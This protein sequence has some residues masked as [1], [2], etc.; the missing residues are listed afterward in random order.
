MTELTEVDERETGEAPFC[1]TLGETAPRPVHHPSLE[2]NLLFDPD[3]YNV[4]D[5]APQHALPLNSVTVRNQ[6]VA[7]QVRDDLL[8]GSQ[9]LLFDLEAG[10]RLRSATRGIHMSRIERAFDEVSP[11]PIAEL[12]AWLA[13]AVRLGQAQET[14]LVT[15]TATVP[16][17]RETPITK[18]RS[19][20]QYYLEISAES[21]MDLMPT[22]TIGLGVDAITACPCMQ[23]YALDEICKYFGVMPDNPEKL[24]R[25]IP[26][27][28]HSQRARVSVFLTST[29]SAHSR[30]TLEL[31]RRGIAESATTTHELLK[32]PDEYEITRRAHLDAKFVEDVV[33][34]VAVSST[35]L[36]LAHGY[37]EETE[38]EVR[39]L[40][41]E[42]IHGHDVFA[43]LKMTLG[44]VIA[45]TGGKP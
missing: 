7:L 31:I 9:P 29:Y 18:R 36:L 11:A 6:R 1:V 42:S 15:G 37:P 21:V 39:T 20:D 41:Y 16:L 33:R 24:L 28:T 14:A 25:K 27:A 2:R 12:F 40:G 22:V 5:H 8:L 19:L 13:T 23:T 35:G 44:Q 34:D 3:F 26:V 17:R 43:G 32:R 10:V 30:A 45:Q 38:I 4:Q